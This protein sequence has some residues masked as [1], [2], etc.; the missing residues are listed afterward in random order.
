MLNSKIKMDLENEFTDNLPPVQEEEQLPTPDLEEIAREKDTDQFVLENKQA[1]PDVSIS[2]VP[3]I[4]IP[5]DGLCHTIISRGPNKGKECCEVNKKGSCRHKKPAP[6]LPP[7]LPETPQ[8][9]EEDRKAKMV[10]DI[11]DA[12][13]KIRKF[14]YTEEELKEMD[15][16]QLKKCIASII[17]DCILPPPPD[18]KLTGSQDDMMLNMMYQISILSAGGAEYL[19]QQY[20]K[21]TFDLLGYAKSLSEKESDI[22]AYL[23]PLIEENRDALVKYCHPVIPLILLFSFT[24]IEVASNNHKKK[25][26]KM[27]F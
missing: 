21:D 8:L 1:V 19:T 13:N 12:Q 11:M 20:S 2:T 5:D 9:N 22:K 18:V 25:S 14:K 7:I 17:Q 4:N 27:R 26:G 15:E 24:G 10:R 3:T 23:K 16:E 6:S